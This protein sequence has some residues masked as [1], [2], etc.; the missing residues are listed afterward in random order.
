MSPRKRR[1]GA[2]SRDERKESEVPGAPRASRIRRPRRDGAGACATPSA[3]AR[4][5]GTLLAAWQA[6]NLE[7]FWGY[8]AKAI[9]KHHDREER[10]LFPRMEALG[11]A[12]PP[13]VSAG[14]PPV[15]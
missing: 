5:G 12:L 14:P 9:A 7:P 10:L 1:R 4:S 13:R 8:V 3:T 11:V 6:D 15:A 2:T